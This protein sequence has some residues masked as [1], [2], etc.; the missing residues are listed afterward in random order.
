MFDA[1]DKRDASGVLRQTVIFLPLIVAVVGVAAAATHSKLTLQ[2]RWRAWL[3]AHVLDQWLTSGRYYQL[4]L[5][6]GDHAN[7]EYRVAEDLRLSVEAPVEFSIGIFSAVT[8]ASVFIG[9]L[10]FIGG[11]LTIPIGSTMLRVPGFLVVAA[12]IYAALASGSMV[13]IARG[14]VKVSENKNQ[15]EADYRY[16]LT[17]LRENGESVA[18]LGGETEERAG[19]DKAFTMVRKRWYELMMQYIRTTTVSQSSNGL[20]PII[21]ILLCAPKYVAGTMTLGEV[22]QAVSAF[23]IVQV[24]FSW[25]VENYPRLADWTA[26]ASRLASLLVSL[27]RLERAEREGATGRILRKQ[28]EA[29]TLRLRDVSVTLD[30][31]SAVVNEADIE[32]ARGEKV[33]VVGESG[34]GKSTLVRAIAGLWPWGSGEILIKFEGL[35][36]MPQEPY[37]P[38]GTLR[39][40]ATYPL[41]PDDVDDAVVRRTVEE[42]G[43]GHL[44][45]RLDEDTTWEHVL[46]GGEK[47]RLAFARVLIQRPDT[48]VMDEAT[49]AL[50]PL[51]Q[52]QLMRLLLERLPDATVISVGHRPELEAFHTRKLVLEYR[53]DGARLVSDESLQRTFGRSARLLSKLLTRKR[54]RRT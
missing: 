36:L 41:S 40:A 17:R 37:V 48:I 6:P 19:L 46:S 44:L 22:M 54:S 8:S 5:V 14:F 11:E 39:R 43:L 45:D 25:L 26:S 23:M 51:G 1:I 24:A 13:M 21:P 34:T 15:A 7:P 18:L 27:D 12:L 31:G 47:Q 32:I 49:A 20:A 42:V 10:W 50:D 33:L 28:A 52:E 38:L 4:N 35:F 3:N 9:V 2:R 16:V 30:D 29:G 53:A